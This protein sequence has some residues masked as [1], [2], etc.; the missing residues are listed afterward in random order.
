MTTKVNYWKCN[1]TL[2]MHGTSDVAFYEGKEYKEVRLSG[3]Y[4]D[5]IDEQ[6][7]EDGSIGQVHTVCAGGRGWMQYFEKVEEN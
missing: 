4:L 2:M 3:E 6:I 7:N 1:K 5:L